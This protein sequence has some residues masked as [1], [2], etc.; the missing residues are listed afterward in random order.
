MN[1][2]LI[3]HLRKFVLIFF[4]DILI[5]SSNYADH[6]A[7]LRKILD[8]LVTNQ[9]FAK[10]SKCVF[11]VTSVHYL[12]HIISKGA[13]TPEP[14]KITAIKNWAMPCSLSALCGFLSL[15]GFYYLCA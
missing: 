3:P 8:L 6:L 12:G 11:A 13:M 9:V 10:F 14:S 5:Y 15:M 1:G 2:L 7:H 4:D